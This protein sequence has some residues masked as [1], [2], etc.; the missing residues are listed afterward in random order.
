MS[1]NAGQRGST[2][3]T[4]AISVVVIFI[5]GAVAV[6]IGLGFIERRVVQGV[7]DA[8]SLAAAQ[9]LTDNGTNAQILAV[10][11]KYVYDENLSPSYE[12]N[13]ARTVR[14]LS[15]E[16]V[17]GEVKSGGARPA[18]VTGVLVTVTGDVKT[19]FANLWGITT[20]HAKAE[21]G[22]GWTPLDVVLVLDK[23]GSMNDDSCFLKSTT[24]GINLR[25]YIVSNPAAGHPAYCGPAP[26]VTLGGSSGNNCTSCGGRWNNHGTSRKPSYRCDWPDDRDTAMTQ[27]QVGSSCGWPLTETTCK[28]CKGIALTQPYWQ[29]IGD[30]KTASTMFVDQVNAQLAPTQP[31]MGLVTYATRATLDQTLTYDFSGLKGK[32]AQITAPDDGNT[33]CQDG[34][35]R[36]RKDLEDN[37]RWTRGKVILFMSDG[38]CNENTGS[39]TSCR[40]GSDPQRAICEA[41]LAKADGVSVYTIGLGSGADQATLR[42]IASSPDYFLYAPTSADLQSA[43]NEMFQ[44]IKRLRLVQ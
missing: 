29:P 12:E 41:G 22:G 11:D 21:G 32:I 23:S 33:N 35:Y 4:F 27:A 26:Q 37:G 7:A 25:D 39:V 9:V 44:K 14:W 38:I 43:F 6:D 15:G 16:N 18:G 36:A 3:V 2:L 31:R 13:R 40:T 42:S 24:K 8:A 28:A 10:V 1:S 17:V 34:L 30:L 19:I 5:C 20:V